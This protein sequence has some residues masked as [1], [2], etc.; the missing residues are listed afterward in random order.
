MP[1]WTICFILCRFNYKIN[2]TCSLT[3]V[4]LLDMLML[5]RVKLFG[6]KVFQEPE[7]HISGE[8]A[9]CI[10]FGNVPCPTSSYMIVIIIHCYKYVGIYVLHRAFY[11]LVRGSFVGSLILESFNMRYIYCYICGWSEKVR[12]VPHILLLLLLFRLPYKF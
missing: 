9:I 10:N 1:F 3:C 8:T 5:I 2:Q 6:P 7:L 4:Q 12:K 11:L